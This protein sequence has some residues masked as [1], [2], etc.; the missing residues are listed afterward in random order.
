MA[1]RRSSR[2]ASVAS[3]ARWRLPKKYKKSGERTNKFAPSPLFL[4]FLPH[5]FFY[6][7]V[8]SSGLFNSLVGSNPRQLH[9]FLYLCFALLSC[10]PNFCKIWAKNLKVPQCPILPGSYPPSTFGA[11][12]LY[13]CVRYGNRCGPSAI[14]ARFENLFN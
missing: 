6:R 12:R 7:I 1:L 13:C 10:I 14:I 11:G 2:R 9:S 3:V 5:G 8:V 4:Y